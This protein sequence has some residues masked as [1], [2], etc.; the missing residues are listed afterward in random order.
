MKMKFVISFLV[1]FGVSNLFSQT[2]PYKYVVISSNLLVASYNDGT[3]DTL[4]YLNN[5]EP[6]E[7]VALL[8]NDGALNPTAIV[9]KNTLPASVTWTR[10]GTGTY[11]GTLASAFPANLTAVT[12]EQQGRGASY[13]I[14]S[15]ERSSNN[16]VALYA[17]NSSFAL[18]DPSASQQVLVTI[19]VYKG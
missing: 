9:L 18:A 12:V 6:L 2:D 8:T 17:M 5:F 3:L 10:T 13:R 16:V 7:Y 19:R 1:L 14:Y 11:E 4:P 15:G